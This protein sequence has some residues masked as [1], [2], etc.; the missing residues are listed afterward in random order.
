[1]APSTATERMDLREDRLVRKGISRLSRGGAQSP[2]E[3]MDTEESQSQVGTRGELE[4]TRTSEVV[5]KSAK[6]KTKAVKAVTGKSVRLNPL[7]C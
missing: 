4:T 7:I 3:D 5:V 2:D 6:H 1:M